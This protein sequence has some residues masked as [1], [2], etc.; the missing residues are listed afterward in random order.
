MPKQQIKLR[1]KS[2]LPR[3]PLEDFD[4]IS[5]RKPLE[6]FLREVFNPDGLAKALKQW[7][8][9]SIHF[10]PPWVRHTGNL[11]NTKG[12]VYEYFEDLLQELDLKK[13]QDKILPGERIFIPRRSDGQKAQTIPGPDYLEIGVGWMPYDES[14]NL[15]HD[16]FTLDLATGNYLLRLTFVQ[17]REHNYLASM[18]N[19]MEAP[20]GP[21]QFRR[22]D[23]R[24]GIQCLRFEV[25]EDKIP[26][27][28]QDHLFKTVSEAV[29]GLNDATPDTAP[30][31]Q[32]RL[33]PVVHYL[34]ERQQYE[35]R[36]RP[37]EY[38]TS[39]DRG[40]APVFRP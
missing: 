33:D 11:G 18:N 22:V 23:L 26:R 5:D 39:K 28:V 7:D 17:L 30:K 16:E 10:Q 8:F 2:A 13:I 3:R 24:D 9:S 40:P 6:T 37:Y 4:D 36:L 21:F 1:P 35:N 19:E 34:H 32:K 15:L 31:I 20:T 14:E 29:R 25:D 12:P 38:I 27:K